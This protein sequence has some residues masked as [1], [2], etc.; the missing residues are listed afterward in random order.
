[1]KKKLIESFIGSVVILTAVVAITYWLG[2]Y[3]VDVTLRLVLL[4]ILLVLFGA[5][6]MTLIEYCL[7]KKK[8]KK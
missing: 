7:L 4:D 3:D 1:M 2:H 5:G 8:N 6:L